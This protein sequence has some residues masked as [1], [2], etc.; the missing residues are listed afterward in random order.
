MGWRDP[1]VERVDGV[2]H[3]YLTVGRERY[4]RVSAALAIEPRDPFMDLRVINFCLSLPASQLQ[5]DGWPKIILRRAMAGML[6]DSV[7]WRTGKEHLGW[8][9]YRHAVAN[10]SRRSFKQLTQSPALL[11]PL[12]SAEGLQEL[13]SGMTANEVCVS[14]HHLELWLR[15][16]PT[17]TTSIINQ[18]DR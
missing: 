11:R 18:P 7:R 10:A 6:P 9:L 13:A 5:F 3:I 14:L 1:G 17:Q 16:Q 12:V 8:S 2:T 4:D 15:S